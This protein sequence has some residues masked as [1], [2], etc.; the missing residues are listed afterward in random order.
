M[1]TTPVTLL[2]RIRDSGDAEAW[3]RLVELA[4]PMLYAWAHRVG[5]RRDDAADL[6]QDVFLL[7][8]VKLPEFQYD[9]SQSFRGW[10]RQVTLNK[11]QER[12]RRA[13][14][15]AS[16]DVE[17]IDQEPAA[18]ETEAFWEGEYREYLVARAMEI[19]QAEFEPNTW[20]ACWEHVVSGRSAAEV[21][22]ELGLTPGAVYVAKCRV[23]KRLREDLGDLM[24]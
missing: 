8:A 18:V 16:L 22:A 6:V 15:A 21:G 2:Q 10:L 14:S 20:R 11:W 23:L 9:P 1:N 7:L 3:E 19:M 17:E 13:R 5:L 24:E 4:T 12:R